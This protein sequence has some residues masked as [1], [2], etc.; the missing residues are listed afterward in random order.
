MNNKLINIFHRINHETIFVFLILLVNLI[1]VSPDLLPEFQEINH[2]DETKYIDSGR[3]LVAGDLRELAR[4]P[5]VAFLYAP[6]YIITKNSPNWFLL[7]AGIGRILL[8][9]LI[10]LTTFQLSKQF[11]RF[12]HPFIA[13]GLLFI[14]TAL[15][16][17]LSNPSDALFTSMSALAL[18]FTISFYQSNRIRNLSLASVFIG[19]A[20]LSRPDG[21]F[22][23][24]QNCTYHPEVSK[25]L[26][27]STI[28]LALWTVSA[29]E[30][31][32]EYR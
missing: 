30:V 3:S 9:T 11:R 22:L 27:L 19:L 21:L 5:L 1:L 31:S 23:F 28:F 16:K 18:A 10:W 2:F 17:I 26:L 7:S 4:G 15:I 8:F 6:L 20:A 29:A 25:V 24:L 13:V 12:F 14:S 32:S